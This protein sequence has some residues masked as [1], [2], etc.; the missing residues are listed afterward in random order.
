ML[1]TLVGAVA[2]MIV[3]VVAGVILAVR[4]REMDDGNRRLCICGV[5]VGVAATLLI[6][7]LKH[8]IIRPV[9]A[10]FAVILTISGITIFTKLTR[11][12]AMVRR[13]VVRWMRLRDDQNG[14]P[15][16]SLPGGP[17]G[18]PQRQPSGGHSPNSHHPDVD[19]TS[20]G[21]AT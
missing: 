7:V 20:T 2:S 10:W 18:K 15:D 16:S 14:V 9:L 13:A 1:F 17:S 3:A 21:S 12:A 4:S 6:V 5:V 8:E 19:A 11:I